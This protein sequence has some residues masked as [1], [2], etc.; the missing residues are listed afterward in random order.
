MSKRIFTS[1]QIE[2]LSNNPN[3]RRCSERSVTYDQ[4]FLF[5]ALKQYFEEGLSC[6]E[7]FI[8]AGIDPEVI[9]K[10]QPEHLVKAW[11]RI[12]QVNGSLS[13]VETRGKGRGG[14]RPRTKGITDAYTIKR[15][16]AENAY[17]KAENAFLAKLRKAAG[18]H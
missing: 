10:R 16:E 5:K 11:R 7:R 14:G 6:G 2:A 15:L 9:G 13:L 1:E 4:V 8:N 17:L 12:W 3:V 18:I